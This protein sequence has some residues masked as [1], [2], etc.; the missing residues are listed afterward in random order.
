MEPTLHDGELFMVNQAVEKNLKRGD[1]VVFSFKEDPDY[2]YVKR[3]I[4][5][6]GDRVQIREDGLYVV[7]SGA[8]AKLLVEPYLSANAKTVPANGAYRKHFKQT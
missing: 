2:F 5:L 1:I 3:I 8:E 7:E 6:P 4:G